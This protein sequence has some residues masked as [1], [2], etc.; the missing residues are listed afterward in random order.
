MTVS[1][2][3]TTNNQSLK[4]CLIINID[5][6][7]NKCNVWDADS[8]FNFNN[9]NLLNQFVSTNTLNPIN[10]N[11]K[12]GIAQIQTLPTVII[13]TP[14]I[15]ISNNAQ[16]TQVTSQNTKTTN[17]KTT[18]LPINDQVQTILSNADSKGIFKIISNV[19]QSNVD[20]NT[21]TTFL[22]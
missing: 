4:R 9:Q 3:D 20:C 18:G 17:Q 6:T 22:D 19:S 11:L 21:K 13:P 8:N 14:T 1:V 15:V 5:N 12:I 2:N 10:A 7:K 16:T